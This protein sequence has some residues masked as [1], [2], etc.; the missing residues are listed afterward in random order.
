ME[1]AYSLTGQRDCPKVDRKLGHEEGLPEAKLS[2]E[3]G[4]T[5]R[6][7]SGVR[8]TVKNEILAQK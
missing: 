7:C 2:A 5:V 4:A 3:C 8:P 1:V 6:A